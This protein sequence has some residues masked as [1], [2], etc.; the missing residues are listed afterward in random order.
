MFTESLVFLFFHE[1]GS[2]FK[3]LLGVSDYSSHPRQLRQSSFIETK[4]FFE[5]NTQLTTIVLTAFEEK[6]IQLLVS[7]GLPF[8]FGVYLISKESILM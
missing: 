4:V 1:S 6:T 8:A 5:T 7:V 2:E 3:R